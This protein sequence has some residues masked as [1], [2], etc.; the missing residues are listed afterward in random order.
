[1]A[2]QGDWHH[3]PDE[4]VDDTFAKWKLKKA[5][6]EA[7]KKEKADKAAKKAAKKAGKP[8]PPPEEK[9]TA[10]PTMIYEVSGFW[11]A[12]GA[13]GSHEEV[14]LLQDPDGGEVFG[15]PSET[16]GSSDEF[17]IHGQVRGARHPRARAPLATATERQIYRSRAQCST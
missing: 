16:A 3:V 13:G 6:D 10:A 14:H 2:N 7:K 5:K 1:M 9:K 12:K 8:W 17:E 15:A 4:G 11:T